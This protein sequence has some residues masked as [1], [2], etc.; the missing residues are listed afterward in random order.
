MTAGT[1]LTMLRRG[2]TLVPS[3]PMFL[4]D[5][6]AIQEGK[7]L[8]VTIR[9]PRHVEQH[10]LFFSVLGEIVRS[11][12]WD[13]DV[14]SLLDYIK[15]GTGLVSTVIDQQTGKAYFVLKSISFASMDQTRFHRFFKRAEWF[16]A[17]RMGVD[18]GATIDEVKRRGLSTEALTPAAAPP[19]AA[20]PSPVEM[21]P[22]PAEAAPGPADAPEAGL[23]ET[24]EA[25]LFRNA[26]WM[27]SRGTETLRAWW[28]DRTKDEK[29][30]LKPEME[31]LKASAE[32]A[33]DIP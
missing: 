23:E 22:E 16:M 8:L 28:D 2:D 15:I 3:A 18:V 13:G 30:L 19:A 1:E 6:L 5:L 12:Q 31:R 9:Q 11:G 24:H 20:K 17:E 33:A 27:A 29:Q 25:R 10:K 32:N 26:E 21:V 4:D 7:E 14:D